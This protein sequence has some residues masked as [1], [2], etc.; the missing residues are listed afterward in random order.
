M[1]SV[2]D[3]T[4]AEQWAVE[5]TLKERWPDRYIELYPPDRE[6]TFCP[7]VFREVGST[8]F[9]NIQVADRANRNQIYYRGFQQYGTG[10]IDYDDITDRVV[11]MLQVRT[12]SEARD[13]EES[14]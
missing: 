13:R 7:A 3:I 2:P 1:S 5:T 6:L 4:E 11:T 10:R 14:T 9:V 12:D 8:S